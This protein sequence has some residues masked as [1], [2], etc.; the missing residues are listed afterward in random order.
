MIDCPGENAGNRR[1]LSSQASSGI[2]VL[3][4][5]VAFEHSEC[6]VAA[7]SL[8][9]LADVTD[10]SIDLF[11]LAMLIK[12]EV[13]LPLWKSLDLK[14]STRKSLFVVTPPICSD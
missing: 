7:S 14:H 12:S 6:S 1:F 10:Y 4:S 8:C 9:Y 2:A 11:G 13:V 3:S 5:L